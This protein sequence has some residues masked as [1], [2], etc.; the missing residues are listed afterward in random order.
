MSGPSLFQL[1]DD[2][3]R[4]I[5]KKS[6][7]YQF[8]SVSRY[9][10]DMFK[11]IKT[12]KKSDDFFEQLKFAYESSG[13]PERS[14]LSPSLTAPTTLTYVAGLP[15]KDIKE[16]V[17]LP[18]GRHVSVRTF[19]KEII[20]MISSDDTESE[21][22]A[23]RCLKTLLE[24]ENNVRRVRMGIEN[25]SYF[26]KIIEY[27]SEIEHRN[28]NKQR[29]QTLQN[30]RRMKNRQPFLLFSRINEYHFYFESRSKEVNS[31]KKDSELHD[32]KCN[33]LSRAALN[34]AN[35]NR[36]RVN[37]SLDMRVKYYICP[38]QLKNLTNHLTLF[39][40]FISKTFIGPDESAN[41]K[42]IQMSKVE[43]NIVYKI[44]DT[45][46]LINFANHRF[47]FGKRFSSLHTSNSLP[48]DSEGR[49]NEKTPY[50]MIHS[51]IPENKIEL[52]PLVPCLTFEPV[53]LKFQEIIKL[54]LTE[55]KTESNLLCVSVTYTPSIEYFIIRNINSSD[56]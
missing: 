45:I 17:Y 3:I 7:N 51:D 48:S 38:S 36:R 22:C 13:Y 11:T 31:I 26:S 37:T 32:M 2:V 46:V 44:Y 16:Q 27:V 29:Q 35:N 23:R 54:Y 39:F 47:I 5:H 20:K 53:H 55:P 10:K 19:C 43:G 21:I 41:G 9:I 4:E 6:E 15:S 52:S 50:Y 33:M 49:T 24:D 25:L 1:Q 56:S 42:R 40:N 28:M 18:D 14:V 12:N 30:W 34:I 8:S